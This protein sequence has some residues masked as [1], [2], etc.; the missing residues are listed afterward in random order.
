M[1]IYVLFHKN[2]VLYFTL[3]CVQINLYCVS[4]FVDILFVKS[5]SN[6]LMYAMIEHNVS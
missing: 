4:V 1:S 3:C 5:L 6:R 2:C